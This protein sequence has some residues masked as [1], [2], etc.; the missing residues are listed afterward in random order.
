[1]PREVKLSSAPAGAFDLTC[2]SVAS[3]TKTEYGSRE[4]I[5]CTVAGFCNPT[6]AEA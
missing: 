3:L 4:L 6:Q 1:M 5:Y 2:V